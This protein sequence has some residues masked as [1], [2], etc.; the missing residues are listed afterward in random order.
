MQE[1]T[2][3]QPTFST[4]GTDNLPRRRFL[5]SQLCLV[6]TA[7]YCFTASLRQ[8]CKM[9]P[10]PAADTPALTVTDSKTMCYYEQ[11]V[12]TCRDWR[13]GNFR[14]RCPD[15][16]RIG[17][18]CGKRLVHENNYSQDQ[19]TLCVARE[20]KV[21]RFKK[22]EADYARWK[23]DPKR[24]ASAAKARE[25]MREL[26]QDIQDIDDQRAARYYD[27]GGRGAARVRA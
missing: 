15:Q 6:N 13:W 11:T 3:R 5:R 17:E 12:F 20:K 16:Y 23:D 19:C 18:T 7:Q 25:E 4:L 27:L 26:A 8:S 10:C 1:L 22:A 24:K 14:Q 2:G 9:K 21:R